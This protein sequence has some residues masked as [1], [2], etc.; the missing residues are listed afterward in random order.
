MRVIRTI[1]ELRQALKLLREGSKKV[2]LVAT[3]GALHAGHL[4]LI[5]QAQKAA[6]VVIVSIFIN[7]KQFGPNEDFSAYPRQEKVD[8]ALLVEQ[9]VHIAYVPDIK[10]MYK[11]DFAT[12]I[13]VG[14]ITSGLCG[15][16]R[17]GHFD[18]IALVVT[19]LLLHAAPDVAIFGEKDYQQLMVIKQLV[20][21]LDLPVKILGAPILREKD[22][23]AISSRNIYLTADE[24]KIAPEL[25]K[26]LREVA[27][28]VTK[29]PTSPCEA[30][31][32]NAKS[33]LISKGFSSIDYL[34]LR[35][36]KTLASMTAKTDQ[37]ARLFVA[38]RLGTCRLIDNIDV[39]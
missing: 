38:A 35:H 8:L 27:A 11:A 14:G 12:S 18:G 33:S 9:D 15:D 37:P 2:A 25:V 29:D 19:K 34:E 39:K 5:K 24:R 16:V 26:T 4:S 31:L 1:Q 22:G 21:D 3:M 7:P 30:L 36:A 32:E 6:D 10:E 28:A 20:S 23:L 17:P 13:S